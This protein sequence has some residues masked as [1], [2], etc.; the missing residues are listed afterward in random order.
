MGN[1]LES[2]LNPLDLYHPDAFISVPRKAK[3][4]D[5]KRLSFMF[6][7]PTFKIQ[8]MPPKAAI[9]NPEKKTLEL[10]FPSINRCRH[11]VQSTK[12][13][14]LPRPKSPSCHPLRIVATEPFFVVQEPMKVI[15]DQWSRRPKVGAKKKKEKQSLVTKQGWNHETRGD[16]LNSRFPQP[17]F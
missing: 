8:H 16:W 10:L 7:K 4:Q 3:S 1:K 2:N 13:I 14:D 6:K 15:N 9:I 5:N 11:S 12:T 17:L